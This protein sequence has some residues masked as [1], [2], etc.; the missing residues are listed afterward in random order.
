MTAEP[1]DVAVM[2]TACWR[3]F[4]LQQTLSA[5]LE[6][7]GIER[8]RR[9]VIGLGGSPRIAEARQVIAD[10]A[11]AAPFEVET[12]ED[13]GKIGP[14][15]A[16]ANAGN[17]ALADPD[18]NFLIVCDEDTLVAD[19]ALD[20]LMW[21]RARCENDP[22]VLLVCAH[23]R[24]C[25]G[26]DGPHVKDNP[27]AD[28][29]VVRLQPYFNQWGWGTWRECWESVLIPD[30]DYDGTSGHPVQSG[31][32]WNIALRTMRGYLAAV[33]DASR[34]QH[35]GDTGGMFSSASTLAWSK[36]ASFRES[37]PRAEYRLEPARPGEDVQPTGAIISVVIPTTGRPERLAQVAANIG[38]AT[39]TP[40][41]ILMVAEPGDEATIAAVRAIPGARLVLNERAASYAGAM[42]TAA[43]AATGRYL[44]A[45][46]DDLRF[47]P[48]WDAAVLAVMTGEVRVGGTND[49][50]NPYTLQGTH[51]THYLIDRRYIAEHGGTWDKGPGTVL[52]EDYDHNFTDCEFIGVAKARG[53][54][55]PCLN[56][57]VE[58]C[59]HEAGKS[60]FDATYARG[61]A[62]HDADEVLFRSREPMWTSVL[63]GA[64]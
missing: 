7:R 6:A 2:T 41:E 55:A 60:A 26:W 35:I 38:Q 53:V 15:R 23:S 19:D 10:F 51:A 5:W 28:P 59:H 45:A 32:D 50:L 29:A 49:L 52:N 54:F 42:N 40:H 62:K 17:R 13:S 31:H 4:Y 30:W 27:D 12:L 56:S 63:S 1:R 39:G 16:I 57:V 22:R 8:V 21:E 36:A 33:P 25:Q 43:P 18:V 61:R 9:F 64:L 37:R 48:G 3:P 44:L 14:W 46:S 47:H 11:A 20:L 34:T 24:C 58:H